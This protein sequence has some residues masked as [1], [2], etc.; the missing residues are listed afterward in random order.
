VLLDGL[1][2]RF[3]RNVEK[4]RMIE[5]GD[6][7]LLGL[8][9]GKDSCSLLSLIVENLPDVEVEALYIDVG[10]GDYSRM[11][12]E[13][14]MRQAERYNVK[15]HVVKVRDLGID[16][17]EFARRTGRPVCATCGLVK[18]YLMNVV[19]KRFGFS[20]IA[21]G[22][23][24]EDVLRFMLFNSIGGSREYLVKLRPFQSPIGDLPAKIKPIYNFYGY[25]TREYCVRKGL[26]FLDSRAELLCPYKPVR[27]IELVSRVIE[28]I[29]LLG[30]GSTRKFVEGIVEVLPEAEEA[31]VGRCLNCGMPTRRK[32]CSFCSM[33]KVCR[34]YYPDVGALLL[35]LPKFNR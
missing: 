16:V 17:A 22:H 14:A 7:V 18:R 13:V 31:E 12:E 8:S 34:G 27:K 26:D 6:R 32:Y 24:L 30:R 21:T 25:E 23:I 19:A 10:Y 4:Y 35:K 9:G 29:E 20:K 11:G 15:L 3:L 2:R 28:A 5:P 1:V 33:Y